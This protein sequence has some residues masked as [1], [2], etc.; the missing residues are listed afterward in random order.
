MF[1][2]TNRFILKQLVY[3][4]LIS[5]CD[6][7]LSRNRNLKLIIQLFNNKKKIINNILI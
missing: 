3:L 4:L 7:C 5:M 1:W 6:S 2:K